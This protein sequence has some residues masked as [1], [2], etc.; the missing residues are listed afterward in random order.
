M[1]ILNIEL[2]SATRLFHNGTNVKGAY[3]PATHGIIMFSGN[4]HQSFLFLFKRN[5]FP[6]LSYRKERCCLFS[7]GSMVIAELPPISNPHGYKQP[8]PPE[9]SLQVT[10]QPA[11]DSATS[12][13]ITLPRSGT[14]C[15]PAPWAPS[16]AAGAWR[17]VRSP[18]PGSPAFLSPKSSPWSGFS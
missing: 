1:Q 7:H 2:L 6:Y 15:L 14:I 11:N 8:P 10:P 9:R 18:M 3:K 5:R 12:P 13:S 4:V 17:T 16:C